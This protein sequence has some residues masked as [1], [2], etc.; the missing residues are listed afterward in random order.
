MLRMEIPKAVTATL[1]I[2]ASTVHSSD[3]K[4]LNPIDGSL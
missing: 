2:G 1:S 3:I 4:K